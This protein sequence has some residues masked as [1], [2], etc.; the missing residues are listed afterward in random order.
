MIDNTVIEHIRDNIRGD[1]IPSGPLSG[2]NTYRTGGEAE[3]LVIAADGNDAQWVYQFA[4]DNGHGLTVIGAGSNIIVPDSGIEGIILKTKSESAR[5]DF[6]ENG[7]VTV[8]AG[9]YLDSLIRC[10]AQKNLG[11]FEHITGIPGTV[12]GAVVMNAG[13]NDGNV[14]DIIDN[15]LALT[16]E[17]EILELKLSDL[18]FGYRTSIFQQ[19]DWL[20]TSAVFNL[21]EVDGKEA[22]RNI[23][24]IWKE[25]GRLYPMQMPNA[26]S[27]F[28]NPEG[29]HAGYLIEQAGLKGTRVGGAEVS[30][31]HGNFI[32]NTG[33]A[34]SSDI[35][36]LI[37]L[38]R[39]KV[40][41]KFGITLELEQKILPSRPGQ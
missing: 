5:I 3:L 33:S 24:R 29:K 2:L 21:V 19:N 27:V 32:I 41:D 39:E 22:L 14:S 38:V 1:V 34:T 23:D 6:N 37:E 28:R 9:V 4:G 17:G 26:G 11:G 12:G 20:I 16:P 30:E 40:Q 13:T 10:S 8:D 7:K 35:I 18:G 31:K 15:V 25:R 36:A